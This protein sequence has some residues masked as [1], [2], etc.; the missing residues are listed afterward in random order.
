MPGHVP[1]RPWFHAFDGPLPCRRPTAPRPTETALAGRVPAPA[2]CP[3]PGGKPRWSTVGPCP[4]PDLKT[5]RRPPRSPG[6][7]I[8][9]LSRPWLGARNRETAYPVPPVLAS[10]AGFRPAKPAPERPATAPPQ[11]PTSN[12]EARGEECLTACPN[13]RETTWLMYGPGSTTTPQRLRS[14]ALA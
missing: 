13:E 3:L 9:A 2:A 7:A 4:S 8:N 12:D 5:L 14:R 11:P 10:L 6:P 1:R